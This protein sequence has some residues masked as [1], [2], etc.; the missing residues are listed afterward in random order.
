V[1]YTPNYSLR[2]LGSKE[3]STPKLQKILLL[4]L[5]NLNWLNGLA[6][7]GFTLHAPGLWKSLVLINPASN[8]THQQRKACNTVE[9]LQH[10][11]NGHAATAVQAERRVGHADAGCYIQRTSAALLASLCLH[12]L[13][14]SPLLSSGAMLITLQQCLKAHLEPRASL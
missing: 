13:N 11:N 14:G 10:T 6:C 3:G 2:C 12:L 9:L 7:C 8:S 1:G 5:T 4:E